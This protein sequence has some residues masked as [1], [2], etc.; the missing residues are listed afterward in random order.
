MTST[1]QENT[2]TL[3][4]SITENFI[5][6][7]RMGQAIGLSRIAFK[8]PDLIAEALQAA[9][10]AG[11]DAARKQAIELALNN[12][13]AYEDEFDKQLNVTPRPEYGEK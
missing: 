3:L 13:A 6:E 12:F 10:N 8:A 9:F 2:H 1:L 4:T 11:V 7:G 5:G